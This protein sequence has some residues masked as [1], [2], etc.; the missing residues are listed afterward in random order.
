MEAGPL[1]ELLAPVSPVEFLEK[2]WGRSFLHIPSSQG[3]FSALFSWEDL[4]IIL[5][6]QMLTP[7]LI[8]LVKDG[9][10][11][12]P[13]EY[14]GSWK[15]GGDKIPRLRARRIESLMVEGA[16]LIVNFVDEMSPSLRCLAVELERAL[17]AKVNINLYAACGEWKGFR[18]HWDPQDTMILQVSGKKRWR[19]YRPTREWPMTADVAPVAEPKDP[20]IWE[21]V[22]DEG[23][24]LYLPRGWWHVAYPLDEPCLHLTVT[25]V[26]HTGADL[27]HWLVEQLKMHAAVRANLPRIHTDPEK[28]QFLEEIRQIIEKAWRFDILDEF[29]S[30]AERQV[31]ARPVFRLPQSLA[32]H[33]E[34]RIVDE[35]CLRLVTPKSLVVSSRPDGPLEVSCGG[36]KWHCKTSLLRA[37]EALDTGR[38]YRFR[39]LRALSDEHSN[40]LKAVLMA[41]AMSGLLATSEGNKL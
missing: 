4:N 37:I 14:L 39:D 19:V 35:S 22:M 38:S 13:D 28:R 26:S 2:Y 8:M 11:I 5:E 40:D 7:P 36:N 24:L 31:P 9:K 20:P 33:D 25:M 27:L 12:S 34:I 10:Q 21:S 16:T 18:L 17:G 30:T 1:S 32:S 41:L 6:H 15:G 3:K 23:G 29:L